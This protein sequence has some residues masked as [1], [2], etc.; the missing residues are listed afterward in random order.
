LEK[1]N[2]TIRVCS[3]QVIMIFSGQLQSSYGPNDRLTIIIS[4]IHLIGG[5]GVFLSAKPI[6]FIC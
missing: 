4:I 5:G 2:I 6:L 3:L 1:D